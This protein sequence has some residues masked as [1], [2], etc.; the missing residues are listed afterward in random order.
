MSDAPH[1]LVVDDDDRI[2]SLLKQYLEKLDYR[3]TVAASPATARKLLATLD[4][5]LAILDIMM[6]GETG[7]E[8]L[9]SVRTNGLKTPVLLLTARGET[10]DRIEGLKA[11]ADDYLAK[12]FEPEELSLRVG[13]ILRRTHVEPVPDEIEMSGL[14][15][16]AKR[17]ELTEGD[18]RVKL[19]EAEL[20]L[21]SMLASR[22]GEP[23]SREEL[24]S[25]SP[26]ST[27]RS[28]DVQVTRLRRKIEPDPKMP[29]HIQTV[30]GV[31]YR[32]MPD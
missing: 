23:V 29:L 27:E 11:G 12:P 15:F 6:P 9:Q 25:R 5:D 4:F 13:A 2:R 24:A 1:I 26:G 28:I 14:V 17:G 30:R 22:A 20:Q 7:L 8:L 19:T 3:V 32:L 21:L 10:A 16:D 31:G 18:R